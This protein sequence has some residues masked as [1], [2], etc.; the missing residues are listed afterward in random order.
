MKSLAFLLLFA[1]TLSPARDAWPQTTLPTVRLGVAGISGTNAHPYVSKQLGLFQKHNIDVEMIAFQGGTQLIQAMLA[2]DLPLALSEGTA[3]LASNV[4]GVNLLFIGGIVN[5]FP[6]TILTKA[7]IKT[8]ADLRGKKI[9]IS[10]FGSSSDVAVRHAVE[11]YDMK[12]D[13]DVVILQVGGQSERFAALRAGAVDAAIVSPPFNLVGRRLSFND[14]I[15]MSESGVAYAHQQIVARKDFLERQPDLALRFLRGTIE[16]LGYWKD[17]SKKQIVTENVA[18]FLKLDPQKDKDQLDETFR[19][20]G[21]VFPSKPYATL[22]GLELS[23]AMLKKARPDA[24]DLQP[25]D[26]VT[27]RFMA[28][29]EKEGFLARVFGGR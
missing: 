2:G 11:R 6:F 29:L 17:P 4:K 21:K 28:E 13:K 18:K 3:V 5:T 16:G 10:R 24:K 20:Y 1:A 23:A 25:K 14:L 19:Y 12:P 9:A 27:N 7:E 8:P 26:S 15:D 22:E